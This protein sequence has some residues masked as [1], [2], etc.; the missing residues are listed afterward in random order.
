MSKGKLDIKLCCLFKGFT[1]KHTA[2]CWRILDPDWSECVGFS[3]AAGNQTDVNAQVIIATVMAH[4][5]ADPPHHPRLIIN[6]H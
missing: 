3:F 1:D 2:L 4:L 5:L 6:K